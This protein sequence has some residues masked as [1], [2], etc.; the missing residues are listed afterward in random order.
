MD[1]YIQF[2]FLPYNKGDYNQPYFKD[3]TARDLFFTR[4]PSKQINKIGVNLNLDFDY[5]FEVKAD[6]DVIQMDNYNFAVLSYNDKKYYCDIEDY[7]HISVNRSRVKLRRNPIYEVVDFFQYFSNF[8]VEKD[9]TIYTD[10]TRNSPNV[11][12]YKGRYHPS[13]L[14]IPFNYYKNNSKVNVSFINYY[15]VFASGFPFNDNYSQ[16]G[17]GEFLVSFRPGKTNAVMLNGALKNYYCFFIQNGSDVNKLLDAFSPYIISVH[18][19]RFP[20]INGYPFVSDSDDAWIIYKDSTSTTGYDYWNAQVIYKAN[21]DNAYFNLEVP[22]IGDE[23]FN[24]LELYVGSV[25]NKL[26]LDYKDFCYESSGKGTININFYYILSK[27]AI[28]IRC[29]YYSTYEDA[30]IGE[31]NKGFQSIFTL[32]TDY[33]YAVDASAK[34]AAENKYYDLLTNNSLNLRRDK[35]TLQAS[36]TFAVGVS[37]IFQGSNVL[38]AANLIRSGAEFGD[39]LIENEYYGRERDY[40]EQQ[41]RAQPDSFS[42]TNDSVAFFS[43]LKLEIYINK[44]TP[45]VSDFNRFKRDLIEYGTTVSKFLNVLQPSSDFIFKG[46]CRKNN[47]GLPDKQYSELLDEIKKGHRYIIGG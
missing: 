26:E 24:K 9:N 33:D 44:L 23:V 42:E 36:S 12:N 28:S 11:S 10:F 32:L 5:L 1:N 22:F 16:T 15:I 38:G 4:Y 35:G 8:L 47:D 25:S 31:E 21:D 3:I 20:H 43:T 19:I 13:K 46:F 41:S 34:W 14:N 27:S 40:L 29:W 45:F 2:Y 18:Y 39:M 7:A 37:Q 17:S 30:P 6:I